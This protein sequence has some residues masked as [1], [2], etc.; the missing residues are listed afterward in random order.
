MTSVV[1]DYV[2]GLRCIISTETQA[3]TYEIRQGVPVLIGE[4][5]LH[6]DTYESYSESIILNEYETGAATSATYTLTIYP[7]EEL[8]NAFRTDAPRAVALG[9]LGAITACALLFFF[10]D[11]LMRYENHERL[12]ILEM[13][14]RFVR[15]I[16]HEIRTPL[17]TVC[18]GLE[19]LQG[20]LR[21]M[22]KGKKIK[23][24]PETIITGTSTHS[25]GI[26]VGSKNSKTKETVSEDVELWQTVVDDI[27]EN[28]YVAVSI[29][30]DLLN[31]DKLETGTMKLEL[32]P[33]FIWELIQRTYS[34]FRIQATNANLDLQLELH[35][36]A[37]DHEK[38]VEAP[39]YSRW[40][41]IGDDIRIAQVLRNI[42]SN[43]LKFTPPDGVVK[44]MTEYVPNGLPDAK[45][46]HVDEGDA[47]KVDGENPPERAGSIRIAI[48]DSGVGMTPAQIRVLFNEGVQ[49]DANRLQHGGGSGLGLSIAKGIVEQH[50]G[51]IVVKSD[52]PGHGTTFLVEFP[53]YKLSEESL[54]KTMQADHVG[55]DRSSRNE[56][57]SESSSEEQPR[58]VLV[59]EDALSSRKMLIRLLERAGHKTVPA[60]NGQV[61]VEEIRKDLNLQ[62]EDPQH[63]PIDTVLT[64]YEMPVLKGPDAAKQMRELGY[65]GIILGVTGNVLEEDVVFFKL[66]GADD[67]LAKPVRMECIN[68]YWQALRTDNVTSFTRSRLS[69]TDLFALE[70]RARQ[71]TSD[72]SITSTLS[73]S[74]RSDPD[75]VATGRKEDQNQV[76]LPMSDQSMSSV[77]EKIE[78][79]VQE[80]ALS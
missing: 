75:L 71:R 6:G 52:G 60:A 23:T 58:R 35:D 9:F 51:S 78:I 21:T 24:P 76:A 7:T 34:Q 39:K 36:S 50:Q 29:L 8:L 53:L 10:Y 57:E 64:D 46:V 13:K 2:T 15:F 22:S 20:E 49:F 38:D 66:H 56:T 68:A 73:K 48:K 41:I 4:G 79:R 77:E 11:L 63:I 27:H 17:N 80:A 16:S 5:D 54:A 31:Y 42:I 18:M 32:H 72:P 55:V 25:N 26:D 3:W 74:R 44:I 12:L 43:A 62:K 28:A 65:E 70:N 1:P 33:V 61:A 45:R 59:A 40:C 30:N 37:P 19:L 14:R 47:S 67:V 69:A